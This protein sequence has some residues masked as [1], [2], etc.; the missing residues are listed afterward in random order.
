MKQ[1][2]SLFLLTLIVYTYDNIQIVLNIFC[3]FFFFVVSILCRC[4][5]DGTQSRDSQSGGSR[6]SDSGTTK[7]SFV[8]LSNRHT[9]YRGAPSVGTALTCDAIGGGGMA[10]PGLL[11]IH[12]LFCNGADTTDESTQTELFA[13]PSLM[14]FDV[15]TCDVQYNTRSMS[16]NSIGPGSNNNGND[17]G[18]VNT[19]GIDVGISIAAITIMW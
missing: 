8:P 2:S 1:A 9:S 15:L 7:P 13:A 17:S 3:N 10:S 14:T 11:D 5:H 19:T 12:N 18:S 16:M 4:R 6:G